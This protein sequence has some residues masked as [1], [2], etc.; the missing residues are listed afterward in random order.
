MTTGRSSST[1]IPPD[2]SFVRAVRDRVRRHARGTAAPRSG[3]TTCTPTGSIRRSRATER[4]R[5]LEP[6]ADPS[7]QRVRRRSP[8]VRHARARLPDVVVG[9]AG[10]AQGLDRP[11]VGERGRVGPPRRGRPAR[12]PPDERAPPRR[13]HHARVVEVG[14]RDRRRER[15]THAHAQPAVDVSPARPDD[16]DRDVRH[17]HV[18]PDSERASSIVSSA[19]SAGSSAADTWHPPSR[20]SG[21]T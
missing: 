12:P 19:G 13:R 6:G 10:D 21:G 16:L 1:A 11:R 8:V 17:G 18:G 5:H 9:S 15:Q 3:S 2:E 14:Q 20:Q 7:L 4:A